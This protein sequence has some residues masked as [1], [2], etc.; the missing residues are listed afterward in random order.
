MADYAP[1][2]RLSLHTCLSYGLL[3]I[4]FISAK[5]V[6]IFDIKV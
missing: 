3:T 1:A 6:L 5:L 2:F 4:E